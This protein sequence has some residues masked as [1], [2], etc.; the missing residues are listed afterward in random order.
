MKKEYLVGVI[1][2]VIVGVGV[3]SVFNNQKEEIRKIEVEKRNLSEQMESMIK[4]KRILYITC[5]NGQCSIPNASGVGTQGGSS[6]QDVVCVWNYVAGSGAF[7]YMEI[8]KGILPSVSID[9]PNNLSVLCRDQDGTIFFGKED[10]KR[11]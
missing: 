2:G 8:T 1:I 6:G 4:V 3:Y 7:P 11:N 5:S 10:E 9:A